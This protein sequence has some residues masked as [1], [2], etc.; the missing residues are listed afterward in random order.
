MSSQT[1]FSNAQDFTIL[2]GGFNNVLGNQHNHYHQIT[3]RGRK[4]RT[5]FD[6]YRNLTRGDI[7][8]LQTICQV[9]GGGVKGCQCEDC[10]WR[11]RVIKTI[12]TAKLSGVEGEFTVVSYSGR[13]GRKAFEEEFRTL[14]RQLFSEVAQVYAI[15]DGT[16]PS[17]VLWHGL[18]P[19][20]HFI[21]SVGRLGHWY[22]SYLHKQWGCHETE[23]WM[24]LSRGMV[25]RGPQ[26]PRSHLFPWHWNLG[27][28]P[29]TAELLREDVLV[30]FLASCKSKDINDAVMDAMYFVRNDEGIP[31]RVDQPTIF[32]T[33][34]KTPIAVANNVWESGRD[35]LVDRTCLENGMTRFRVDGDGEVWLRL[36]RDVGKAWLSQ[37]G[38]VFHAQGVLS[39]DDREGF[40]L[41]YRDAWLEGNID[42]S[43]SKC[44]QRRQQPVYLFVYP[45]P[46]DLLYENT[47]PFHHWSF[48]EDGPSQL[49]PETCHDLGLPVDLDFRD[50]GYKSFSWSI[51]RYKSLH[52]YQ[53]LRGF[54][55]TTTDFARHL[56]Y[57]HVFQPQNDDDRFEDVCEGQTY[58]EGYTDL[59]RSVVGID[60]EYR[61]T[62]QEPEENSIFSAGLSIDN[63]SPEYSTELDR[64]AANGQ[65]WIVDTRSGLGTTGTQG[66]LDQ[67]FRRNSNEYRRGSSYSEVEM[68]DT[69]DHL[70]SR[71][72]Q[73]TTVTS[74]NGYELYPTVQPTM[75]PSTLPEDLE[76]VIDDCDSP[77]TSVDDP[78]VEELC[79]FF[80]RLKIA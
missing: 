61:S 76:E 43:P 15:H 6:D 48:Y 49:S 14:S 41:V 54:D 45:P 38:R 53:L 22:L 73:H 10:E 56:G 16:I 2:G 78:D 68:L 44:R 9:G 52:H 58:L 30:R 59:D 75:V 28:V 20:A 77:L 66:Y 31:E 18:L 71:I 34:T 1:F 79:A 5:E 27:E 24:D 4:K 37:A 47:S 42:R 60:P 64:N 80:E 25:C 39:E 21:G 50:W 46:S 7:C 67:A 74:S 26:G 69:S 40:K 55:P 57:H 11:Q 13:E 62:M 23:L 8:K 29:P 72:S 36:N 70:S 35:H 19:L 32:S 51:D 12:C 17:M 63:L 3:R 33:R 65:R